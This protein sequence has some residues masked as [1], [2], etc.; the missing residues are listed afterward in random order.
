MLSRWSGKLAFRFQF[1]RR[2]LALGNGG[3][4]EPEPGHVRQ[5][6]MAELQR[7]QLG[8]LG[9]GRA[10]ALEQMPGGDDLLTWG[11]PSYPAQDLGVQGAGSISILHAQE[12]SPWRAARR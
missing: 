7:P 10:V 4:L 6:G 11:H 3:H 8:L 2:C 1:A 12:Y 9:C 5:P